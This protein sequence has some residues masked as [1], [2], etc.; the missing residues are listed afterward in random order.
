[1]ESLEREKANRA[2][3]ESQNRVQAGMNCELQEEV[4][5]L[6]ASL[7]V[8]QAATERQ[9]ARATEAEAARAA[10]QDA[11]TAAEEKIRGG[12]RLRRKMHNTILV[13]LKLGAGRIAFVIDLCRML[14]HN[15]FANWTWDLDASLK[16]KADT[17]LCRY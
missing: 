8:A 5:G 2:V 4:A 3:L 14:P 6:R 7:A 1:M 12:E 9:A 15:T 11:L 17:L 16:G 10:T 13:R